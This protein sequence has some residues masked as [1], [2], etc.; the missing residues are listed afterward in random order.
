[1]LWTKAIP[2]KQR[3]K[4]IEEGLKRNFIETIQHPDEIEKLLTDLLTSANEE[5]LIIFSSANTM[6]RYEREGLIQLLLDA[7]SKRSVKIRIL[8]EKADLTNEV[9]RGLLK[10]QYPQIEFQYLD[11]SL[12][13]RVTTLIIDSEFSLAIELKDDSKENSSEAMGLASYSNS[14]STVSSY[15]SIFESLWIQAELN[16]SKLKPLEN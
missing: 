16:G 3:I 11:K 10:E 13:T 8:V 1:M 4:E 14:E 5:I 12:K 15:V 2:A 7:E 6:L 9:A